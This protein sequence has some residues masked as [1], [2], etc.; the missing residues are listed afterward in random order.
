MEA[1]IVW[2]VVRMPLLVRLTNFQCL[3]LR[4]PFH[5][6]DFPI[7]FFSTNF[8]NWQWR[9]QH[10]QMPSCKMLSKILHPP[11]KCLCCL[12]LLKIEIPRSGK[13][14][15]QIPVSITLF[16]VDW[17]FPKFRC[18][19]LKFPVVVAK[20]NPDVMHWGVWNVVWLIDGQTIENPRGGRKIQS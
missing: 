14:M 11:S 2:H 12:L 16:I 8:C 20:F 9:P 10:R 17:I 18:Y 6:E 4:I 5:W 1:V 3:E 7:A 13:K 19:G 15:F